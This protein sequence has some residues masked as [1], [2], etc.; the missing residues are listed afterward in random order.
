MDEFLNQLYQIAHDDKVEQCR[1]AA[2]KSDYVLLDMPNLCRSNPDHVLLVIRMMDAF[3]AWYHRYGG[4]KITQRVT[5]SR[6]EAVTKAVG[7]WYITSWSGAYNGDLFLHWYRDLKIFA[8]VG[9][10]WSPLWNGRSVSWSPESATVSIHHDDQVVSH[11]V[12]DWYE[13]HIRYGDTRYDES[14]V[15]WLCNPHGPERVIVHKQYYTGVCPHLLGRI[16][17]KEIV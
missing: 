12:V 17:P 8:T 15:T 11:S 4:V 9:W 2:A 6:I 7:P 10:A 14:T 5:L 3:G 16:Y 1:Q 13:E